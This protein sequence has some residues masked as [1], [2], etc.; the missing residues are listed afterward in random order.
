MGTL[1]H[2][3]SFTSAPLAVSEIREGDSL[4]F[5]ILPPS[6]DKVVVMAER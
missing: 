5:L 3:A 2:L 6:W 4:D 1:G